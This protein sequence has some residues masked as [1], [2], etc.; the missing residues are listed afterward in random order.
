[1]RLCVLPFLSNGSKH[2]FGVVEM[3]GHMIHVSSVDQ[4]VNTILQ[5]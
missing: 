2:E 4:V 5:F 1:M 3:Q